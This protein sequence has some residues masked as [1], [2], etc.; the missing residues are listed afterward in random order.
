[1]RVFFPV[2]FHLFA[3]FG[4]AVYYAIAFNRAKTWIEKREEVAY[5]AGFEQGKLTGAA[6]EKCNWPPHE[7]QRAFM[8]AA[9]NVARARLSG[10][11]FS[12]FSHGYMMERFDTA[13]RDLTP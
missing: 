3:R 1:V 9:K 7:K 2:P 11:E 13:F 5:Q 10:V 12:V 6:L 8:E 4:R